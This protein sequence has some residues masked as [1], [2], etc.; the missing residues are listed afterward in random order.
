MRANIYDFD[1]NSR[2]FGINQHFGGGL[3]TLNRLL[4]GYQLK[5]GQRVVSSD[6]F[7]RSGPKKRLKSLLLC[8]ART[9]RPIFVM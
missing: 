1:E 8:P 9:D 3:P 7:S 5:A 4:K 2:Q 6:D